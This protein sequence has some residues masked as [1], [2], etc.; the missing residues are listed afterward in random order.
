MTVTGDIDADTLIKK[1]VKTGKHAELWPENKAQQHSKNKKKKGKGKS[2]KEKQS[3][4]DSSEETSNHGDDHKEKQTGKVEVH[5]Q[6]SAKNNQTGG[7]SKNVDHG[8]NV[9]KPNTEGGQPGKNGGGVTVH[10]KEPK[11]EVVKTVT[12]QVAEKKTVEIEGAETTSGGAGGAG[13]GS[14]GKK[15][16]KKGQKGNNNAN[17]GE[18]Q[19]I[20]AGA[21]AS[22]GSQ[23]YHATGHQGFGP[24]QNPTPANYIPPHHH[25][26]QYPQHYNASPRYEVS[27]NTAYPS[28]AYSRASYYTSP[29]P[30]T[31]SY[32]SMHHSPGI[33]M[34]PT[35]P[36]YVESYSAQ[37]TDS[38]ELFSDENPN[39]CSIM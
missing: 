3:D 31:Y 21:P 9:I 17:E 20:I 4:S 37:P 15:K 33:D 25:E 2:N 39:G 1:L 35:A 12:L 38:F 14:G 18:H 22:T 10:V 7:T 11:P 24:G 8:G 5:C 16:K 23:I 27:Y 34:E 13:G 19:T 29:P 26:Y 32:A 6:D 36:Y 30:Y 28:S